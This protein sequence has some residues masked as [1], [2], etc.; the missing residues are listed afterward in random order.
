MLL[1]LD[2]TADFAYDLAD[3]ANVIQIVERHRNLEVVFQFSH[4]FKN[5]ERIEPQI[6]KQFAL[7]SRLDRP[8]ADAL[9]DVNRVLFEPIG[10]P[11]FGSRGQASQC[12]M[13]PAKG[14]T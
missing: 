4:Q 14:A 3:G 8:P 12:S 1:R 13:N 5:L 7:R 11:G 10:R 9:E 6:G 2:E